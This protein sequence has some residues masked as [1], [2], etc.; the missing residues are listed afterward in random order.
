MPDH[1]LAEVV[2]NLVHDRGYELIAVFDDLLGRH[3]SNHSPKPTLQSFT[4]DALKFFV[5]L[6]EESLDGIGS[7]AGVGRDLDIRNAAYAD[8]R[9]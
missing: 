8:C 4:G 5:G 3:F 2:G 1:P 6:I 9:G 7:L